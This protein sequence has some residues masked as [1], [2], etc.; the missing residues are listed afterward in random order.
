MSTTRSSRAGAALIAIAL[1]A[2]FVSSSATAKP[3]RLEA[4]DP[5]DKTDLRE[6]VPINLVFVGYDKKK[7]DATA[8]ARGLPK[9]YE[10]VARIPWYYGARG[11]IGI[12]YTYDYDFVFASADYEDSVFKALAR[13]GKNAP[14]TTYQR[15]YN[16]QLN[17]V[18]T[19]DS[20]IEIPAAAAEK[21]LA[22]NPPAGVDTT[23]NTLF[24][25]NWHGRKDFK[26]HVYTHIGEPKPD[27][28]YD[29]GVSH[30]RR[31]IAWGGT[32]PDD[33]ET[34][35]GRLAR[36]WFYDLSAGPEYW[37]RNWYVDG[38]DSDNDRIPEERIPP[39][40]EY[41][42]DGYKAPGALASDL[43]RV[44]RYVAI[45][46]LFTPSPLY[47]PA[48]TPPRLPSDIAVDLNFYDVS[49]DDLEASYLR[50]KVIERSLRGLSPYR[51][52]SADIQR[53]TSVDDPQHAACYATWL[54]L[55]VGPS[56]Y[57]NPDYEAWANLFLYDSMNR[58]RF[59]DDAKADYEAGSFNY[60]TPSSGG[61]TCLAF[62][63]GHPH[64]G[65][66]SFIY[67]FLT[68]SCLSSIGFTDILVHEY[69]HHFGMSHQHDGYDHE[70][71]VQFSAVSDAWLFAFAGTQ[72]N[73]VMS[74]THVN[75]E[76]S[77]FDRDNISR[78]LTAGYFDAAR[79][80]VDRLESERS[81]REAI[82]RADE[83]AV[84]AARDFAAHRYLEAV[85]QARSAYDLLVQA[86]MRAG[87]KVRGDESALSVE[88]TGPHPELSGAAHAHVDHLTDKDRPLP[89]L[90]WAPNE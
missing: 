64:S 53:E 42:S 32:T 40:W 54:V 15:S 30:I 4:L 82:A 70:R 84:A 24:F 85:L 14:I 49:E 48:I 79:D 83:L 17:N 19:I 78:W 33:P 80:I 10:P 61:G 89:W 62:A 52:F 22:E 23:E 66:Q 59:F 50:P 73:S 36:V 88:D 37:T 74:Y 34:G 31:F 44:A 26:F 87:I 11:G 27:T 77:Q 63:D 25:L 72:N 16:D 43:A 9:S 67:S 38:P 76:F 46:L 2:T 69:G 39:V 18:T 29:A 71:R 35:L 7:V 45:D 75:N 65:K 58:E 68:Q 90:P 41:A 28:G 81:A 86:A 57:A 1:A 51:R 55:I 47:P 21:W 5:A 20:N 13:L 60:I 3:L 56:C 8:F 12:R 6:R